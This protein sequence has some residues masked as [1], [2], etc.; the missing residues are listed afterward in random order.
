MSKIREP[1]SISCSMAM[2]YSNGALKLRLRRQDWKRQQL[3][4]FEREC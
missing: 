4:G 2:C 1:D 3:E